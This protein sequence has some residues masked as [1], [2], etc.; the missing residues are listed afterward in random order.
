MPRVTS[1]Y[2]VDPGERKRVHAML[3]LHQ[4]WSPALLACNKEQSTTSMETGGDSGAT[5]RKATEPPIGV[6]RAT[7][8]E[9]TEPPI[10]VV[11]ATGREVTEPPIGVVNAV[12][13]HHMT[14]RRKAAKKTRLTW[15][16]HGTKPNCGSM[17]IVN[18]SNHKDKIL[19]HHLLADQPWKAHHGH[20]MAAWDSL[21]ENLLTEK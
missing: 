13:I 16:H 20:V 12:A 4:D 17:Y 6:V 1:Y 11:G 15:S 8:T 10:G 5:D 18:K 7:G 14:T 9:V 19:I 21:L 3:V 2:H